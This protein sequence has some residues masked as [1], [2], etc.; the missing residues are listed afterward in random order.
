[1]ILETILFTALPTAR[2]GNELFASVLMSPQLGG[3]EG[4]PKRL[5]LSRYSDFRQGEWARIVRDIEW[6]LTLRW[7]V[8]DRQEDYLDAER[9]SDDPDPD[10]FAIMFPDDMPVDPYV[11]RNPA[12][13]AIVSYPAARLAAD[14][15]RMQVA[16]ARR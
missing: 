12:D 2:K 6:Q 9:I 3:E 5:P 13:A 10:L 7:S 15:D 4:N 8:D 1:M 11:F 14:L 16:V